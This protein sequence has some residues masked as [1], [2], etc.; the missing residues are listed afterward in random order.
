MPSD[1]KRSRS[2][3]ADVRRAVDELLDIVN[4][5]IEVNEE[6]K[7]ARDLLFRLSHL[8]TTK[9][10][11]RPK[12]KANQSYKHCKSALPIARNPR[13]AVDMALT[14]AQH[15]DLIDAVIAKRL[16]GDAYE[17]YSEQ[18]KRFQGTS[19]EKLYAI[20]TGLVSETSQDGSGSFRLAQPFDV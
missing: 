15:L 3:R 7:K 18:E 5:S 16:A 6:V 20:R 2:G 1:K 12:P 19:L 13:E 10:K 17:S 8:E 9:S 4:L 14:A 11:S